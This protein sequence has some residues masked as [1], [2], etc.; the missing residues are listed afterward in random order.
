MPKK[1]QINNTQDFINLL[2]EKNTKVN[3]ESLKINNMITTMLEHNKD[4][5]STELLKI[6]NNLFITKGNNKGYYSERGWSESESITKSNNNK[7][8]KEN[9]IKKYGETIGIEKWN[10]FL[11]KS[12]Q[13]EKNYITK[14]GSELG[15]QKWCELLSK[16][17][18]QHSLERYK[19]LYGNDAQ[20]KLDSANEKKKPSLK[21]W[22]RLHGKKEGEAMWNKFCKNN[23]FQN[24]L[25][26]F[27][28]RY[29]EF[30]GEQRYLKACKSKAMT[31]SK[32]IELYG[33]TIGKIKYK[34][35]VEKRAKMGQWDNA[36]KESLKFFL[37][38]YKILKRK[39]GIS[40]GDVFI[41]TKN[42][43]EYFLLDGKTIRFYDFTVP[44]LNLIIEYHGSTWHPNKIKL[45]D[46]E[47]KEW[48]SPFSKVSADEKYNDDQ[49]K[50]KLAITNGYKYF[51]VWDTDDKKEIM[52]YII[53]KL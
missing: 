27:K 17:K 23:S 30:E 11:S 38:I 51:E 18:K 15:K 26:G 19:E 52:S 3:T 35:M 9:F 13:S 14:Y 12:H 42:S 49:Y 28:D 39:F 25:D 4:K 5:T 40:K 41:G 47:W 20:S 48:T 21:N 29:G 50:K 10:S 45:T 44:K 7:V 2:I 34:E 16:R 43:K 36:S 46:S 1:R 31:E 37:P 32:F 24:T 33:D 6:F 22:I 8:T 53:S